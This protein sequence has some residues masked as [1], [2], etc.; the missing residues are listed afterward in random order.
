MVGGRERKIEGE[1]LAAKCR[2]KKFFFFSS[3]VAAFFTFEV[4]IGFK[5]SLG[6]QICWEDML[7]RREK[8]FLEKD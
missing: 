5:N 8:Y 6:S 3:S 7:L 2:E 4:D 1:K